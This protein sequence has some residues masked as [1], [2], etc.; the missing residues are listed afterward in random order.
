MLWVIYSLGTVEEHREEER[1]E[2]KRK[3]I[4]NTVNSGRKA[5]NEKVSK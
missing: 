1:R 4:K 5:G 3:S 2:L